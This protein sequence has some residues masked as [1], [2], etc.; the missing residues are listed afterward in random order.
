MILSNNL[1]YI[2]LSSILP[3]INTNTYRTKILVYKLISNEPY[4]MYLYSFQESNENIKQNNL[5]NIIFTNLTSKLLSLI[6]LNNHDQKK[7]YN[8]NSTLLPLSVKNC[9]SKLYISPNQQYLACLESSGRIIILQ[10]IN[11]KKMIIKYIIQKGLRII[12]NENDQRS[13]ICDIAWWSNHLLVLLFANGNLI[14]TPLHS[15]TNNHLNQPLINVL[16]TFP[17]KFSSLP[18]LTCLNNQSGIIYILENRKK[19]LRAKKVWSNIT[20]NNDNNVDNDGRDLEQVHLRRTYSLLSLS[21]TTAEQLI[22]RYI[23]VHAYEKAS[24]LAKAAN[25]NIERIYKAKWIY[26]LN[27]LINKNHQKTLFIPLNPD[28][29]G[30]IYIPNLINTLLPKISDNKWLLKQCKNSLIILLQHSDV[31]IKKSALNLID[32]I[33]TKTEKSYNLLLNQQEKEEEEEEELNDE[34]Y[35]QVCYHL[36]FLYIKY[37]IFTYEMI[38]NEYNHFNH[39]YFFKTSLFNI[40]IKQAQLENL[41]IFKNFI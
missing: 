35:Q 22:D 9:Q 25:I 30:D 24:L 38:F 37:H 18:K 41:S 8:I 7:N 19:Y 15:L 14:I 10:I 4:F 33:L 3:D 17:E 34:I 27:K 23:Q 31:N 12:S 36:L 11:N 5:L 1:L 6:T 13:F 28:D 40:C 20:I 2:Y 26:S 29:C 39:Q 32:F 16:G 21:A